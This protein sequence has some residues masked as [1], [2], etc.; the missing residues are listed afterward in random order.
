[1]QKAE[2][3]KQGLFRGRVEREHRNQAR[4]RPRRRWLHRCVSGWAREVG[5]GIWARFCCYQ[6]DREGQAL[7]RGTLGSPPTQAW[8][9][10]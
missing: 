2:S 4:E 3:R 7:S 6:E 5:G 10:I 1:M 8:S 9:F